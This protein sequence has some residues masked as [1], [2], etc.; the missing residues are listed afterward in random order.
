MIQ[1]LYS[2]FVGFWC[3]HLLHLFLGLTFPF[4]MKLLMDSSSH[5]RKFHITEVVIVL[6]VALLPPIICVNVTTHHDNGAICVPQSNSV[7]FYG[8]LL[9]NL[10][11]FCIGLTFIF[12][13][14]WI[15]R[16]VRLF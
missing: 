9:P 4:K 6:L 11:V 12:T 7:A 10:A 15:L 1:L 3:F 16:K 5:R 2:C 13:S 8:R 14:F